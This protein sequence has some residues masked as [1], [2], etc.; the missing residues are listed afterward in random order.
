MDEWIRATDDIAGLQAHIGGEAPLSYV[1]LRRQ[2]TLVQALQRWPLLRAIHAGRRVA[3][4]E[5]RGEAAQRG[6]A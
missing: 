1:D 2:E 5:P 4:A 6:V 3:T